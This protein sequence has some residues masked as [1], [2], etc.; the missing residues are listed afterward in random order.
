MTTING[1]MLIAR[2]SEIAPSQVAGIILV[3]SKLLSFYE[4]VVT[5]VVISELLGRLELIKK[6]WE[7]LLIES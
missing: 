4:R 5:V 7:I 3:W 6:E 1:S 2:D